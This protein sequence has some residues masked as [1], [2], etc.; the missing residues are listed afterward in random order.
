MAP[1]NN[2]QPIYNLFPRI[3]NPL[4]LSQEIVEHIEELIRQK[5]ILPGEK[6]P[7][8]TE[9]CKMFGVSRTSLRE[10]LQ[11]LSARG[12]LRIRKG[13]GIYVTDYQAENVIKPMSLFLELNLDK[14]YLMSVME[15]RKILEPQIASLAATRRTARDLTKLRKNCNDLK[16]C[17]STDYLKQGQIDKDFHLNIAIASKNQLVPIIVEPMFRLMPK[18]RSLV[19]QQIDSAKSSAITYHDLILEKIQV[20]D[21]QGA[22]EAMTTHLQIAEE[23]TLQII[24]DLAK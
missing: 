7:S 12:L 10:A 24:T 3:G 11:K 17:D 23:H 13:S 1:K 6:L 15:I 16:K 4:S 14:D 8:E 5:K 20:K 18:I 21:S 22:F 19:Y 9:L 2:S